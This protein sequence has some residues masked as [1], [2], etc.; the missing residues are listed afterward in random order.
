MVITTRDD[1]SVVI[2]NGEIYFPCN[3]GTMCQMVIG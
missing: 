1:E 2:V 3:Y